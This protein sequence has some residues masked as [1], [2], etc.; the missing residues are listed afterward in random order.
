MAITAAD[1]AGYQ[2]GVWAIDPVHSEVSFSVRHM[3]LSKVRGN[4][5][6]FSGEI[7]T[8][9]DPE[10]SAVTATVAA[11]SIDTNNADRDA[12]LRNEDFFDTEKYPEISFKSTE[13]RFNSAETGEIHGDLT[14][15]GV[16][17]PVV[18]SFELGGIGTDAYDAQRLGLT[19]VA[20]IDRREFDLTWGGTVEKTGNLIVGNTVTLTLEIAAV[21]QS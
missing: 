3:G 16:T 13:V 4:F 20:S 10:K 1:I 17:K 7:T 21:L 19:A 18:F 6:T 15:H 2:E 8:A 5:N 11:D 9:A 12:H 14:L